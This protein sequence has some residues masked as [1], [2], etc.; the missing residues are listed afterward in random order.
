MIH[1]ILIKDLQIEEDFFKLSSDNSFNDIFIIVF[2]LQ[3][4][5]STFGKI[6]QEETLKFDALFLVISG[7]IK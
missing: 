2:G 4:S 3:K 7:A 5:P 6:Y 1:S